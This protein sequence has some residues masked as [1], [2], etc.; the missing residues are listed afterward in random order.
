MGWKASVIIIKPE[1]PFKGNFIFEALGFK[2]IIP[3]AAAPFEVAIYPGDE[4]IF[5]GH[6]KGC[7]LLAGET[8]AMNFF[9]SEGSLLEQ[10]L[11]ALTGAGEICALH[12][13]SGMNMWGYIVIR[14][15][16]RIRQRF[17]DADSGTVLDTGEPLEEEKE[18]LS[19]ATLNESGQRTYNIGGAMYNEDQVGENFVFE[20]FRRYTGARMDQDDAL[21]FETVLNGYV[22]D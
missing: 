14:D 11:I 12:L 1:L 19:K 17:G 13:H 4:R 8:M 18:L 5:A 6:Y 16:K 10:N 15:G 20:L 9:I 3:A 22:V 2:N 21:L 7:T